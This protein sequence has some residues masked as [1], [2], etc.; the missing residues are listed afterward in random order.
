MSFLAR[1]FGG[2]S[3]QSSSVAKDRLSLIIASQRGSQALENVDMAKLQQDVMA[4]I[5]K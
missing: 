4:I 1:L 2:V 5:Q 3:A